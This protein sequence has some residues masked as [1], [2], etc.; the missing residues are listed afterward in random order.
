MRSIEEIAHDL[1][2]ASSAQDAT[3]FLRC[4]IE[5][6][7]IGTQQADAAAIRSR[8]SAHLLHGDYAAA[9]GYYRRALALYEELGDQS[10]MARVTGS[11]GTVY[12][13]TGDYPTALEHYHRAL[14]LHEMLDERSGV[15]GVTHN[16]GN[17][18][19]ETG[20]YPTALE[21]YHRALALFEE[22]GDGRGVAQSTGNIGIVHVSTGEYAVALEYYHR[23][24][25]LHEEL[26]NRTGV[27]V[28][29]GNIGGALATSGDY[30]AALEKYH[31]ALA[32]HEE[33]G[34]RSGAARVTGNILAAYVDMG[35]DAE[36][37][38]VLQALDNLHIDH[39]SVRILCEQSRAVLLERHEDLDGAAISLH[40]ALCEAQEHGLR[41]RTAE[42]HKALRDLAQKRNDLA[43]YIEHNNEYARITE[44]INGK[45]TATKL[46]MQAKQ[47]E[48]DAERKE[49]EK[50][51]AVLH[52]TLPKHIAD[53]VARGE[54]VN[55]HYDSAAVIFL[56]IVGFTTIS[57]RIP[58]GH[59]VYLLEQIFSTLDRVCA[60]H[61]VVKIK[62]IGDSYMAVSF[63]NTENQTPKTNSHVLSTEHVVNAGLCAVEMLSALNALEIAMPPELGDTSWTKD[64]GDIQ[65][66]IGMHCGPVT[67]GVIG[68]ERM[69]YDVW[70]DTVNVASRMES[71][72]EPGRIHVS[73]SFAHAL[74]PGLRRGDD[75]LGHP[76]ESQEPDRTNNTDSMTNDSMT[77]LER[78]TIDVKGK[79]PMTTYWLEGA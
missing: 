2:Q 42:V 62:T 44:E 56:D 45:E 38:T 17:V 53:R 74:D 49:T 25:T 24:L 37:Q 43:A 68:T 75:T 51:L 12:Q 9:L 35:S 76:G 18:H 71:S 79:G 23:A 21:C 40:R 46:A 55:D 15:A 31:S 14:V 30:T 7:A 8:G 57:D 50:Q 20:D 41:S 33:L 39:P 54:T 72:G 64:V 34:N 4:A 52:S 59:V 26:A 28:V 66:R 6:D 73:E 1:D 5:L 61:G 22:L 48:I 58:S 67:A 11:I 13:A 77:L 69:Q 10:G 3:A 27:A 78:G 19:R 29:T 70:G 47:R 32:L 16:I 63:A 65:V 36:A 60:K